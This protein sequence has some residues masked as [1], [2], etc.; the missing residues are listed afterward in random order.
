MAEAWKYACT[1]SVDDGWVEKVYKVWK[2][3]SSKYD[4]GLAFAKAIAVAKTECDSTGN[5]YGCAAA[6]AHAKAWA[7]AAVS[8]HASAWAEA[9]AKCTCDEKTEEVSAGADAYAHEF[10]YLTANVTATAESHICVE[11]T[12]YASNSEEQTC[13]QGLYAKVFAKVCPPP[14]CLLPEDAC[15]GLVAICISC[16]K[17]VLALCT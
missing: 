12:Q 2:D 17:D 6:Y 16:V 7:L 15:T 10:E 14:A 13:I 4:E 9:R 1:S 8:A 3:K 5:A 11:H